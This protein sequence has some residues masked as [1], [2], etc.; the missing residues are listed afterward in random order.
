M[1]FDLTQELVGSNELFRRVTNADETRPDRT[2]EVP[3]QD[4]SLIRLVHLGDLRLQ[5]KRTVYFSIERPSNQ[6]LMQTFLHFHLRDC[7]AACHAGRG[8]RSRMALALGN[9]EEWLQSLR[10]PTGRWPPR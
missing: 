6:R 5:V 3:R 9:V 4:M 1:L 7:A 8:T 10:A 2:R